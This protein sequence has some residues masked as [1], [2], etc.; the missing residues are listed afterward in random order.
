MEAIHAEDKRRQNKQ[1]LDI[2]SSS[3]LECSVV[4]LSTLSVSGVVVSLTTH[5]SLVSDAIGVVIVEVVVMYV[6]VVV[7]NASHHLPTNFTH[8]ADIQDQ[9]WR[10]L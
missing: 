4:S 3:L 5:L 10:L 1:F 2:S 6:A 8:P 7:A 9:M